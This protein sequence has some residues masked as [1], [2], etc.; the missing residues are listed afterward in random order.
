MIPADNRP[1]YLVVMRQFDELLTNAAT[2]PADRQFMRD[3]VVARILDRWGDGD[4]RKWQRRA[5]SRAEVLGYNPSAIRIEP[6]PPV[7]V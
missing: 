3:R 5:K 6:N 4:A 2:T 7:T 1:V